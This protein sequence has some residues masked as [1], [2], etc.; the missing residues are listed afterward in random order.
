MLSPKSR[1][2]AAIIFDSNGPG[3]IA[4]TVMCLRPSWRA[5]WRR[6]LVDRGLARRVRVRLEHR[7]LDRVDR[8]DVDDARR[9]V[10]GRRPLRAAGSSARVR[11]NGDFTLRSSTLS[12]ASAGN[13]ASGAPHVAPALFTRMLSFALAGR[14]LGRELVARCLGREVGGE[15]HAG[16]DLRELGG[17]LVAHVLLAGRDVDGRARPRRSRGRSSAR[18]PR[19]PPVTSAV[20]PAMLNRSDTRSPWS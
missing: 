20:L 3:A 16:A 2:V 18:C 17:H 12:H 5:R 1:S 7:H 13:S 14:D 15:A 10:G 4:L 6:Q 8:T 11:K 19:L 9:V